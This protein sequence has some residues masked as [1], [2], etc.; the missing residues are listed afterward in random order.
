MII[1]A[2]PRSSF[3]VIGILHTSA[4]IFIFILFNVILV[5]GFVPPSLARRLV[6][7]RQPQQAYRP[8]IIN[9]VT[10]LVKTFT[11][12]TTTTSAASIQGYEAELLP[13]VTPLMVAVVAL[14]LGIAAQTFINQMLEGDQGLG[15]FLKDGS[16]YNK[17]GFRPQSSSKTKNNSKGKKNDPLPWLK[18]PQLDF[19]DVAGQERSPPT[20][21]SLHMPQKIQHPIQVTIPDD[22]DDDVAPSSSAVYEE[23]EQLRIRLNREVQ[24]ENVKEAQKIQQL[25]ERRMKE[26][27]IQFA[28]SSLS[29]PTPSKRP[30]KN[31][32]KDD[33]DS[34]PIDNGI[35]FQ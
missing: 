32:G 27:G 31:D 25:L 8:I 9:D 22:N 30:N 11:R 14:V 2:T 15:A 5:E 16:G 4:L 26:E 28:S 13:S 29:S 7:S 21:R 1:R 34:N 20:S 6:Q 10:F 3:A 24:E 23:L 19:V 35:D 33:S 17:S 12:S 18:L